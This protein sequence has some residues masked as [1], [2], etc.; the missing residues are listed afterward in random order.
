MSNILS[1]GAGVMA[2]S[3][4]IPAMENKHFINI[5]GT[6][7]DKDIIKSLK[8]QNIHP[9]LNRKFNEN[10]SSF[11]IDEFSQDLIDKSDVIVIGV[12]SSGIE[13]FIDKFQSYSILGKDFLLITKGLCINNDN[14][15]DVLPNKIQ[16]KLSKI[17]LVAVAGPCK[18]LEL[19]KGIPTH[20]TFASTNIEKANQISL[21]F[22]NEYYFISTTN[23]IKGIEYCSA[24]KN[25]Y[26]IMVGIAQALYGD[27]DLK[28]PEAAIFSQSI[29]EIAKFLTVFGCNPNTTYGLT[30]I[31]D[32]YV[33]SSSGRNKL[34][35][36]LLGKNKKYKDIINNELKNQTLEGAILLQDNYKIFLN[37]FDNNILNKIEFPLL[38][39]L[40]NVICLG[41]SISIPWKILESEDL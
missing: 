37:Y 19:A 11:Y 38:Y 17:N 22:K 14:H 7:F 6:E 24:L 18:A 23:D 41:K 32:L 28:N 25:V 33:T 27:N 2:S 12:N 40:I 3:I 15:L 26:A 39:E 13:W 31:G 9:L 8:E 34:L 5:V 16:N 30:G 36:Q 29:K 10:T 20:V 35:G 21:I 1:I 4:T